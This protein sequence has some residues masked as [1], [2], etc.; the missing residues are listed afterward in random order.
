MFVAEL[1]LLFLD[2]QLLALYLQPQPTKYGHIK[3]RKSTSA[4]NRPADS[5]AT[6]EYQPVPGQHQ[7]QNCPMMAEAE[8]TRQRVK[9]LP[10]RQP[11][12]LLPSIHTVLMHFAK[13]VFVR[14]R[15]GNARHRNRQNEQNGNLSTY[16]NVLYKR[17]HP[18]FE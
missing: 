3:V 18:C 1:P 8:F 16:R 9:K 15:P 12:A 2:T 7:P 14:C 10:L 17:R 5:P 11:P 6:L 4:E 13:H